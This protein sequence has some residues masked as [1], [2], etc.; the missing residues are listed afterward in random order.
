LILTENGVQSSEKISGLLFN[1]GKSLR[2]RIQ[3]D[4]LEI[5]LNDP[6][7]RHFV[8][9]NEMFAVFEKIGEDR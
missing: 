2:A 1:V 5:L 6:V 4:F 3:W 8:G 7:S 9:K